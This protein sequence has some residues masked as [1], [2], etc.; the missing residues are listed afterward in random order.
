M[1][2]INFCLYSASH[3][4][5]V[6]KTSILTNSDYTA[7]NDSFHIFA[8]EEV[9][10]LVGLK[11]DDAPEACEHYATYA[12]WNH[13][14]IQDNDKKGY[15]GYKEPAKLDKSMISKPC[16]FQHMQGTQAIDLSMK[17]EKI[18]SDIVAFFFG[19]GTK[20][21]RLETERCTG[22]IKTMKTKLM[23]DKESVEAKLDFKEIKPPL[24]QYSSLNNFS[25]IDISPTQGLA[26]NINHM[27]MGLSS[28]TSTGI[29]ESSSGKSY[30]TNSVDNT[31]G[32]AAASGCYNVNPSQG[33]AAQIG[34]SSSSVGSK[35]SPNLVPTPITST[36]PVPTCRRSTPARRVTPMT[37]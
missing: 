12:M 24:H 4:I 14:R 37:L 21:G 8:L 19:L 7:V 13:E 36:R 10:V 22:A 15:S 23:K 11:F 16:N 17:I 1:W 20:A 2:S 28:K 30:T 34:Q 9:D 18:K 27:E 3:E 31:D 6:W 32:V 29:N 25:P 35:R 5:I 26:L 33:N